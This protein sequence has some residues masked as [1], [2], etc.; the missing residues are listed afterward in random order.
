MAMIAARQ[1]FAIIKSLC[2]WVVFLATVK[3]FIANCYS[4][5]V[6]AL[7]EEAEAGADSI[8]WTFDLQIGNVVSSNLSLFS[9]PTSLLR[10]KT[11]R[12]EQSKDREKENSAC[13]GNRRVTQPYHGLTP[14]T[15]EHQLMLLQPPI[16]LAYSPSDPDDTAL[17]EPLG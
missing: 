13:V 1:A 15:S 14:T 8:V 2:P 5:K 11:T 12:R 16:A 17:R 10:M 7:V 3:D 4:K 9:P 6:L